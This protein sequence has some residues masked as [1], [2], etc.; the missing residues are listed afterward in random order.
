MG[1]ADIEQLRGG[2]GIKFTTVEGV[3][4]LQEERQG[5]AFEE[6]VLFKDPLDPA[7]ARRPRLFVGLRYAPASSKPGPAGGNSCS[8]Q[9]QNRESHFVPP[10]VSFCSLPDSGM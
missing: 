7:A 8:S 5:D 9:Q 3:Q 6:L 2:V 4:G 10:A 1:A